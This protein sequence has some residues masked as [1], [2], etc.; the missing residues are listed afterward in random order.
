VS[1][2]KLRVFWFCL[3]LIFVKTVYAASTIQLSSFPNE[4]VAD[5]RSSVTI[6]A[7]VRKQDGSIVPDGTQILFNTTLGTFR[8]PVIT[9]V[10]GYARAIL[11]AGGIAGTAKITAT[12]ISAV[13]NPTVIEVDFV[14]S[15]A[16]LSSSSDFI[17]VKSKNEIEYVINSRIATV[18]D[19]ARKRGVSLKTPDFEIQA[20]SM[21]LLVDSKEVRAKSALLKL[22]GKQYQFEELYFQIKQ[23]KG[24]A[25]ANIDY[26]PIS[27]VI[28]LPQAFQ[29]L[30]GSNE[31]GYS[32]SRPRKR[33]A[34]VAISRSGIEIPKD[35]PSSA[36]FDFKN[37]RTGIVAGFEGEVK[38]EKKSDIELGR[39]TSNNLT[40]VSKREIQFKNASIYMGEQKIIGLQFYILDLNAQFIRSP[41]EKWITVNNSQIGV[42]YPY[43]LGLNR[44]QTNNV[45][46]RTG[47]NIGRGVNINRGVF[48][49]YETNWNR[50]DKQIGN[51]TY[52]G[53]GRD[54]YNIGL[55]QVSRLDDKTNLSFSLDSP[56]LKSILASTTF[57]K[58]S[59]GYQYS[60]SAAGQRNIEGAKSNRQDYLFVAEKDPIKLGKLPVNLFYGINAS[61]AQSV[62]EQ[63]IVVNGV[64]TLSSLVTT[65][66]GIGAR[67]RLQ[68]LPLVLNKSNSVLAGFTLGQLTGSAN[69]ITKAGTVSLSSRGRG[70]LNSTLTYD[71]TE[72]GITE[73]LLGRSRLSSQI[74]F[75]SASIDYSLFT[76]KALDGDRLSVFGDAQYRIS[77][78]WG[79]GGQYTFN[80]FGGITFVD[81]NLVLSHLV[82]FRKSDVAFRL[83]LQYLLETNRFGIVLLNS[84]R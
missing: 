46:F 51:F 38:G 74:T 78:Y 15:K 42:D 31:Y 43:Y 63:S 20:N 80:S 55:R 41:T 30:E 58:Q 76:T 36:I 47:Q 7:Q 9:T 25:L 16:Q 21:Q 75:S 37:T 12:D 4:V 6:T 67:V 60:L 71:F 70:G 61:Y 48:F 14:S 54:D 8:E 10:N 65:N 24:F 5:S 79:F 72:D 32:P 57:S 2:V 53:I 33:F 11:I 40:I 64:P 66:S 29:F 59:K 27:K 68:S 45:R 35:P 3:L 13:S 17:D 69:R 19:P 39:I 62:G 44:E 49:D 50:S 73:E 34:I 52:S 26:F 1:T 28:K 56:Q 81:Y 84:A 83:G 82:R 23:K 77:N 18:D 22:G